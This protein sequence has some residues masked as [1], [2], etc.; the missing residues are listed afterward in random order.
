MARQRPDDVQKEIEELEDENYGDETVSGTNPRPDADDDV[1]DFVKDTVGS[2]FDDE[3]D[4]DIAEEVKEDEEDIRS[5]EINDYM[6]EEDD[7][8]DEEEPEDYLQKI[9]KKED[10]TT[11]DPMNQVADE[12]IFDNKDEAEVAHDIADA[13]AEPS[14]IIDENDEMDSEE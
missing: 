2:D 5:D 3:D 4:L 8:K 9:E 11:D 12:T 1:E 10:L 6:P 7:E 13:V 14:D